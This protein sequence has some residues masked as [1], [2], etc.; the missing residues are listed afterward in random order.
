MIS[1]SR[2]ESSNVQLGNSYVFGSVEKEKEEID[3]I[4]RSAL[5]SAQKKTEEIINKANS[6]AAQIIEAANQQIQDF[7]QQAQEAAD[8]AKEE[9]YQTGYN[10]GYQDGHRQVHEDLANQIKSLNILAQSVF[11]IKKE[12]I[13]SSEKEIL[14]L[15]IV[16]AEK[17]LRQQLEIQP[18]II[19]NIIK[20]AINELKDK[21]EVNILVNPA[22]TKYLYD[23]SEELKQTINGLKTIKIMEDKTIP[24]DGIIIESPEF[25]IDARLETQI[26]EI[27]KQLMT[28]FEENPVLGEIPKEID[29]KIE[30]PPENLGND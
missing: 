14:Q 8:Q 23:F 11:K 20:A 30:G 13:S 22:I 9:G 7:L 3:R 17:I 10:T 16:I 12:I 6:E 5:I 15:T 19:L 1:L 4:Q 24:V 25:R 21:E 26:A 28:N 18:E 27:A 29:I 2:I